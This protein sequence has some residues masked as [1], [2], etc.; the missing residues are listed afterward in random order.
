MEIREHLDKINV[1]YFAFTHQAVYTCEQSEKLKINLKGMHAKSLLLVGKKTKNPYMAILPCK[2][3]LNTKEIKSR[4]GEEVRFADEKEL[5]NLLKLKPGSVSPLA[6]IRDK[7]SK[8]VV[9]FDKEV[10]N[11]TI[12]NFH[13]GKNTETLEINIKEFKKYLNTIKNK[14]III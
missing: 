2:K 12:V 8:I 13:P 1:K 6:L 10:I 4:I 11:S 3:R 9:L 14:I 7:K 5:F